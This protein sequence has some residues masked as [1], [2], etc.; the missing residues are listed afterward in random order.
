MLEK[1]AAIYEENTGTAI[2]AQQLQT[3]FEQAG[4][5]MRIEAR[6]EFFQKLV[7]E[8]KITQDE[9]DQYETWLDSRPDIDMPFGHEGRGPMRG[10]GGFGGM[11]HGCPPDTDASESTD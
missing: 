8:G 6:N 9:A 10:F 2:D 5:E 3:A 7:G 11:F 1:V 4:D